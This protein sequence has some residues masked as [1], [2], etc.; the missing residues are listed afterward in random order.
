MTDYND[1]VLFIDEIP[2]AEK[3]S[4]PEVKP[5]LQT[6]K[7]D[8]VKRSL[9]SLE[10]SLIEIIGEII[11]LKEFSLTTEL[12]YLG[13]A[14]ISA[15]KLAIKLYKKFGI[16]IAVKKLLAGTVE[17]I[18][19]DL[20]EHWMNGNFAEQKKIAA[21]QLKSVRISNVQRGIYLE[22][23]KNPLSTSYNVPFIYN[24]EPDTDVDKLSDAVKK[25]IAAPPSIS[26]HFE[27]R[28]NE[29]MLVVNK[30]GETNISVHNFDEKDFAAFKDN[31]VQTFKLDTEP[32]YRI[33]IVKTAA[34]V[35]L[36][37]DF[38]HIIF[39]GASMNLFLA[40]LKTLLE[41]G[42]VERESASYFDF[43]REEEKTFDE[44][45][46]FFANMLKDFESASEITSDVH[47]KSDGE[48]KIF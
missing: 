4:L 13:L 40:N 9:N 32:L 23:M 45:K 47:G 10:K 37:V 1:E 29:I 46:K 39:D 43:V 42:N 21:P 35:S 26:V 44:N 11:G 5:E 48:T 24:F 31:F 28:D 19:N 25:I 16:S 38:H 33:E 6:V 27:L 7:E 12:N 22:C 34:R 36:F 20:L 14:S 41:G 18:E 3:I 17:S 2:S 15:I 8:N 30:N